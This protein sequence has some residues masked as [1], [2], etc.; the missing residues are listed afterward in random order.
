M[1][2]TSARATQLNILVV[3]G[4]DFNLPIYY[5]EGDKTTIVEVAAVAGDSAAKLTPPC[6]DIPSGAILDFIGICGDKPYRAITSAIAVS[7][8]DAGQS[9]RSF[10]ILSNVLF[11]LAKGT[12]VQ[13]PPDLS[14]RTW[15]GRYDQGR[16]RL[17]NGAMAP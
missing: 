8:A 16:L 12:A 14:G 15:Q 5:Y 9:Y 13:F 1:V 2:A 11:P 4:S 6:E 3:K 10:S 17:G 7:G